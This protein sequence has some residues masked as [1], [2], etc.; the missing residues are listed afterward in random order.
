VTFGELDL[1]AVALAWKDGV[2]GAVHDFYPRTANATNTLQQWV[3]DNSRLGIPILFIE[4]CL[5]GLQD[6]RQPA[7]TPLM[8][9]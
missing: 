2:G 8:I 9:T 7:H 4:E 5:H 1:E 3:K 6:V